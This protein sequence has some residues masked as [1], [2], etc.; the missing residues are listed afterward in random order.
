[1]HYKKRQIGEGDIL[2]YNFFLQLFD[3]LSGNLAGR[4]LKLGTV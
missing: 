4:A 3:G 1:M 2:T